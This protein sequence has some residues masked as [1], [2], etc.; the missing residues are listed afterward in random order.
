MG[1]ALLEGCEF[2]LF[3]DDCDDFLLPDVATACMVASEA[4]AAARLGREEANEAEAMVLAEA[5]L[6]V[7]GRPDENPA[8]LE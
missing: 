5:K 1:V 2:D 3:D 8:A 4:R 6:D 7:W